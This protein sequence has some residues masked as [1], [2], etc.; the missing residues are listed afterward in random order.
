MTLNL[1]V[2]VKCFYYYCSCPVST[3][4]VVV[5]LLSTKCEFSM[6]LCLVSA[7]ASLSYHFSTSMNWVLFQSQCYCQFGV[8]LPFHVTEYISSFPLMLA[9]QQ[10]TQQ[11]CSRC[12]SFMETR[13]VS[14]HNSK[15]PQKWSKSLKRV[16]CFP[17]TPVATRCHTPTGSCSAD[18]SP[19]KPKHTN[20][21]ECCIAILLLNVNGFVNLH[22]HSN[23]ANPMCSCLA[24]I[25][26]MAVLTFR[27]AMFW[28]QYLRTT[29]PGSDLGLRVSKDK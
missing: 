29:F 10:Q 16:I 15:A 24:T 14:V 9:W 6:S 27:P 25:S 20:N 17:I 3:Y 12:N 5:A 7:V 26:K 28:C 4:L 21:G 22:Q 18:A 11:A 1:I 23:T 19:K 2:F 8:G 13:V